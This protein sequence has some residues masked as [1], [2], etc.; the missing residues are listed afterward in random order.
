M[1]HHSS[2]FFSFTRGPFAVSDRCAARPGRRVSKTRAASRGPQARAL[3]ISLGRL[4]ATA[5]HSE[6]AGGAASSALARHARAVPPAKLYRVKLDEALAGAARGEPRAPPAFARLLE[7]LAAPRAAVPGGAREV[8]EA[9]RIAVS[10]N[11]SLGLRLRLT[12]YLSR[13]RLLI[14]LSCD[15][16]RSARVSSRAPARPGAGARDDF[17][18]P[19]AS[20]IS[21]GS[22]CSTDPGCRRCSCS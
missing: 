11:L 5:A 1:W 9:T 19:A 13:L 18:R 2:R 16:E 20:S 6:Q 15:V 12:S 3:S 21:A 4:G 14:A 7:A 10:D 8:D 17:T 22:T